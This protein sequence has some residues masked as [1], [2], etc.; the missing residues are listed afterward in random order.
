MCA[1]ETSHTNRRL[2][3][4]LLGRSLAP[5][6]SMTEMLRGSSDCTRPHKPRKT[7]IVGGW[8]GAIPTAVRGRERKFLG[9]TVAKH[10]HL[11]QQVNRLTLSWALVTTACLQKF[12]TMTTENEDTGAEDLPVR[13]G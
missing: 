2:Q 9:D 10:A 3:H 11:L 13:I 5:S 7:T 6:G 4:G 12:C 8:H 1:T